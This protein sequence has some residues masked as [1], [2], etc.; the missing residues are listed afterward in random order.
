MNSSTHG[1]GR[2]TGPR[3]S[4][5]RMMAAVLALGIGAV[6]APL[7]AAAPVGATTPATWYVSSTGSDTRSCATSA[8]ACAT[9][10]HALTLA[11][12]GDTI[13]VS[14]TIH[15]N[16]TITSAEGTS[17]DPITITGAS[18]PPNSPA[19]VNGS[20]SGIDFLV[21]GGV[22][23]DHLTMT[24]GAAGVYIVNNASASVT[25]ST[26]SGNGGQS[27]GGIYNSYFGTLTVTNSTV[28]G[29]TATY[30]SGQGGYGGGI[31]SAGTATIVSSTITSNTVTGGY[32]QGGGLWE[33]LNP[34]TVIASTIDGN[35]ASGSGGGI[36]NAG[37]TVDLGASIVAGNT[38]N[39][40]G[41]NCSGTSNYVSLNYN[42]SNDSTCF[43]IASHDQPGVNSFSVGA[44]AANGGP[45]QTMLPA[46]NGAAAG[47]I[48]TGTTL[49]S[50]QVCAGTDQRGVSR[51][52]VAAGETECT[53]GAT[54]AVAGVAP[55]AITSAS[56]A[57]FP[58]GTAG[59]FPMAATGTPTP[60]FSEAGSLPVGVS[61]SPNGILSGTPGTGTWGSYPLAITA[62]NGVVPSTTQSFTLTVP[63]VA[64]SAPSSVQAAVPSGGGLTNGAVVSWTA[65]LSS[66]GSAISSYGITPTDQTTSTRLSTVVAS[67]GSTTTGTVTGLTAGHSYIFTVS[68]AN[69]VGS[70]GLSASS[71]AVVPVAVAP[72]QSSSATTVNPAASAGTS[73]G[74]SG[75]A[76]SI[77]ATASGGT[78]TLTVSTFPS[79]PVAGFS[80]G[81]T[82]FDLSVSP[83]LTPF[84]GVSFTVCGVSP[85]NGVQWWNPATQTYS[86]VSDQTAPIGSGQCSTVIVNAST[87]P[88]VA[89][90]YGTVF[91]VPA[92]AT[93]PTPAAGY[94][95][96]GSDGGV[97]SFGT[98]FY[99][100]TGN[101]KLNQPVFA[102]TPTS[103]GKG[104][105]FVA[106]DGGVFTYGDGVFHG[107]VPALGI[108]IANIVGMAADTAT[109]GYW[110]V[111]S[112]GGVYAFGAPFDGSVPGLRQHVSN[113]VGI[114]ATADGGGYYLASSTGA[115]YAFGDAK[116]RG[117]AN[118]L[119][120]INAAIVGIS[121][122]SATGGYWLAGSDGGIYAYGAPYHGSG[123]GSRLN[124][125]VVGISATADGS[126]YYLVAGDGGVFSYNAPFLGSGGGE[127]LNAPMVGIAVAE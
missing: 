24:N 124:Q 111:G 68:A 121:V 123:G 61:L 15:D 36:F 9:I 104:Y 112:D 95:L 28:T 14:G 63:A 64:P 103:A 46:S 80:G 108:H 114:S 49:A 43:L 92:A 5:V 3:R 126:G 37:S 65:P 6:G 20:A 85:S 23:L 12:P 66:G 87:S 84:T 70:S 16:V 62:A 26:V 72:T 100:S 82:Y 1:S 56:S 97:F 88:S 33:G 25:N 44:L 107:S 101:L 86:E 47:K 120:R 98:P 34:T 105:W 115:V 90:L 81:G 59:S 11:S 118:T 50:I 71:N 35:T 31:Y 38:A 113:I 42:L 116:Y 94:W 117:G 93:P 60:S 74:T 79:A 29:N 21:L 27:G 45:T 96:V 122:D 99:G 22:V 51:P 7:V 89:G 109:G 106:R 54:E 119:A 125:P 18:A 67:G 39:G 78:G 58:V 69:G 19:V 32:G 102:I 2:T 76:G 40:S 4:W 8:T 91:V 30:S 83:S 127:H 77:A 73:V 57:S 17:G 75:S 52:D 110:L 48:P 41:N 55:G 13:D 10:T 53:V